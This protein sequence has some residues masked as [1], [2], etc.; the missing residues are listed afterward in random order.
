MNTKELVDY[1]TKMPK[2]ELHVH[3]EGTLEPELMCSLAKKHNI[4]LPYANINEIK[5]AYKFDDLQSFLDLYYQG[6][7]VLIEED[8]FYQLM[9]SY[10]LKCVK[11]NIVH[12]EIM[13]DPQTHTQRG[14]TYSVFMT[15][16]Q[17]AIDEIKTTYDI[18]VYLI[19]SFLRHLDESDAIKTL[20]DAK[21]YY[22]LIKAVGLDSSELGNHR[23]WQ[24][25]RQYRS[26]R[27]LS[28]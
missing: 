4:I 13:F 27:A 16:F 25:Y 12:T 3:I 26:I 7:N 8:D 20:T 11:Q 2:V 1:V 14:I 5:A 28:H 21:E 22:S 19:L 17:R 23:Y 24:V 9:R 6:A 18:S 15:G 10:L